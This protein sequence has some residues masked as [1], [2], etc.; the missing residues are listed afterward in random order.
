MSAQIKPI[1]A[2]L[3]YHKPILH[4]I[5]YPNKKRGYKSPSIHSIITRELRDIAH[6]VFSRA[7]SLKYITICL[8]DCFAYL[9]RFA[10]CTLCSY[11]LKRKS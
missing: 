3:Q 9:K 1:L 8:S 6:L 5:P 4:P 2:V 10:V 7:L 11:P